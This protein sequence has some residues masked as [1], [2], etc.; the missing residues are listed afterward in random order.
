MEV[1]DGKNP[2]VGMPLFEEEGRERYLDTDELARLLPVLMDDGGQIAK[3]T[4]FLLATGLRLNE[5]LSCEWKNIDINNHV[6]R[7]PGT[8]AK[9]KKTDSIPLNAAAVQVLEECDRNNDYPFANP[10]TGKPF[11]SI[12]KGFQNLM[13]KAE[14]RG[15]TAHTLR[16]TA[17]SLMINSG[18][19]LYDVQKVL[20]HSSSQ[21]TEKYAHL[22]QQSVMAASDTI[23]QQLQRAA[24]GKQ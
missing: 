8:G 17:A 6:M 15:V 13:E 10:H 18:R 3:I 9:S 7:I 19:S 16:H 11:V 22:S 12:K 2:A 24:S 1:I 20:R 23:S 14:L 4:R 5:C 21:F